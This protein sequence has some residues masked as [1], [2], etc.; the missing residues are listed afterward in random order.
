METY[1]Q[2][3]EKAARSI[4]TQ[5]GHEVKSAIILGSG[6]GAIANELEGR[7]AIPYERIPGFPN[8]TI[9]GHSGELLHGRICGKEV[10][11]FNGRFH[12]Y[13]GYSMQEVTMPV[14]VAKRLGVQIIII[15]NACGGINED[16]RP[17]DIMLISDHINLMGGN[18]LTGIDEK[19]FGS[20]FVDMSDPYDSE[21]RRRV[22]IVA[23]ANTA[24][25]DVREGIYIG[26]HGPSYETRAEISF[27]RRIGADAVGMSTVPEV[28]VCAQE[29]IRV[30][31]VSAVTNMA[32]G[33]RT[34]PLTHQEVLENTE[35]MSNRL[36]LLIKELFNHVLP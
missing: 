24:I 11:V 34:T 19:V 3:V 23:A 13:E 29:G 28:T 22:K 17:G 6:L 2:I 14:R 8:S 20:P 26:V 21:L 4:S 30:I 16:F 7:I 31:G 25:G 33:S 15:T 1:A 27:F 36:I 35:K 12:V 10:I 32:T 18:P 9:P 5:I